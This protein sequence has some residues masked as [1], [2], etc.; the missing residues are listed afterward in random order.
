MCPR[1]KQAIPAHLGC[2]QN[3]QETK[4]LL[5]SE[6]LEFWWKKEGRDT[7]TYV[8]TLLQS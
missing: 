7:C 4:A 2:A 5:L 3:I 6:K 1:Q 8:S